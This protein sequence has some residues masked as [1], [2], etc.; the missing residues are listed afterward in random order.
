[1]NVR[2]VLWSSC[3]ATFLSLAGKAGMRERLADACVKRPG[4]AA[5]AAL[6][7][8]PYYISLVFQKAFHPFEEVLP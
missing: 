6:N 7:G 8:N 4:K 1:M 5:E 3:G 2:A